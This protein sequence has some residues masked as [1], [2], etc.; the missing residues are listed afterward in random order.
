M[1]LPSFSVSQRRRKIEVHEE[2]AIGRD[3]PGEGG[4]PFQNMMVSGLAVT[5]YAGHDAIA[6]PIRC[7]VDRHQQ[8]FAVADGGAVRHHDSD[9]RWLEIRTRQRHVRLSYICSNAFGVALAHCDP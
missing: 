9:R 6:V 7:R 3:D 5:D 8:Y 1:L 2:V 4:G